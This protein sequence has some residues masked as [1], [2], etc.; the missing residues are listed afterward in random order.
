MK[1]KKPA[2]GLWRLRGP[3]GVLL[4]GTVLMMLSLM[5]KAASISARN[6]QALARTGHGPPRPLAPTATP[7]PAP[8][9]RPPKTAAPLPQPPPNSTAH[10][11]GH[12]P[13][14]PQADVFP[15]LRRRLASEVAPE[16]WGGAAPAD[17]LAVVAR[18]GCDI[19]TVPI[20]RTAAPACLQYMS[21]IRNWA[22]VKPMVALFDERTIKFKIT[23]KDAPLKAILKVPQ[24]MFNTEPFSERGTYLADDILQYYRVPPTALLQ[25]PVSMLQAAVDQ[26]GG[27][28]K[29]T[30][31]NAKASGVKDYIH[32]VQKD[33]FQFVAEKHWVQNQGTDRATMWA[34]VQLWMADVNH[35]LDTIFYIPYP[36][37]PE[38]A[39]DHKWYWH[40]YYE[41]AIGFPERYTL[42]LLHIASQLIFDYVLGNADRS[43]NKNNYVVGAC[44]AKKC[45]SKK[46]NIPHPGP[47]DFLYLDHGMAFLHPGPPR[48]TPISKKNGQHC[49]FWQ[50][51]IERLVQLADPGMPH[52][53]ISCLKLPDSVQPQGQT[54]ELLLQKAFSGPI[55]SALGQANIRGCQTRLQT[56]LGKICKCLEEW[57]PEKVYRS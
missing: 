19:F 14:L 12:V 20:N 36:R 52:E 26:Y 5:Y 41:P 23:F 7:A 25:V 8:S 42:P 21:N 33:V 16:H 6:S 50:P 34:S 4:L 40:R 55:A 56:L 15:S 53:E 31:E 13:V 39:D 17:V 30:S 1:K 9:A 48:D 37:P 27:S 29:M 11:P 45:K 32:W 47:P 22:E 38:H 44:K 10:A 43:P 24:R 2:A 46:D 57:P 54:L 18:T 51:S 35:L 28:M 49:F 3:F